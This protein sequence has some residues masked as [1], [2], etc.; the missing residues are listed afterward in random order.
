M[1]ATLLR[2]NQVVDGG[3]QRVDLDV[4]TAGQAVIRK[5]IAGLGITLTSTG[6]DAG[7]G[8]VTISAKSF[9]AV[10]LT[11]NTVA[12]TE[13][14]VA[15]WS[16]PA[17]ALASLDN[18]RADLA[19]Q[20]SSTATLTFRMRFGTAGTIAD[21]LL[22]TFTVSAAGVANAYHFLDALVAILSA[23]TAT[24]AGTSALAGA[25]VS[26]AT[27]AF[28]AATVNLTVANF[29]S[30]TLVQSVAQTYTSRA[31]KLSL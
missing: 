4:I 12:T 29:L 31:A 28:A 5:A 27:A 19:G 10:T 24:A 16:I 15:R 13:I 7:T 30:I 14:I 11:N 22:G 23:T 25:S 3:I 18:L 8:D 9:G 17:N 2:G 6:V 21:A 20:V 26:N 1:A